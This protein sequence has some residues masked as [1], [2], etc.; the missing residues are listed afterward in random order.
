MYRKPIHAHKT[1]NSSS[2][3]AAANVT[4]NVTINGTERVDAARVD[5]DGATRRVDQ[6]LTHSLVLSGIKADPHQLSTN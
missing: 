4:I 6:Y 1:F 5:S 3:N 2:I